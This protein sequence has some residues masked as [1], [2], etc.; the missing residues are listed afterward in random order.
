MLSIGARVQTRHGYQHIAPPLQVWTWSFFP[1][2]L[3]SAM[4]KP[5]HREIL[6]HRAISP[7]RESPTVVSN[8]HWTFRLVKIM[9]FQFLSRL[10]VEVGHIH[11]NQ[12][13]RPN[14]SART[15]G[16]LTEIPM[17]QE[18]FQG[19]LGQHLLIDGISISKT[20][21]EGNFIRP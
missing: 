5:S 9:E 4:A 17:G 6:V 2:Y 16:K 20:Q 19:P 13:K 21:L 1:S 18:V 7:R 14:W 12:S 10:E 8:S 15:C 3:L 11:C